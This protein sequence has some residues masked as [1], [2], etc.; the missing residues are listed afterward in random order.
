MPLTVCK[1]QDEDEK[2]KTDGKGFITWDF[3]T[4]LFNFYLKMVA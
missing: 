1:I 2:K 4:F 3:F